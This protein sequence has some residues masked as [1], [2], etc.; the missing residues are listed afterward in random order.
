MSATLY[1]TVLRVFPFAKLSCFRKTNITIR[2]KHLQVRN[3]DMFYNDIALALSE[4]SLLEYRGPV[5]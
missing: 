2:P 3:T 1:E 5:F 4:L